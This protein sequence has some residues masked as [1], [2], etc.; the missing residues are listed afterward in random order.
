MDSAELFTRILVPVDFSPASHEAL[1]LAVRMAGRSGA[2]LTLMHVYEP[3]SYQLLPDAIYIAS[4]ELMA[5]QISQ[6]NEQLETLR[7]ETEQRGPRATSAL[8][9]GNAYVELIKEVNSGRH[10]LVVI[11]THGNTGLKHLLLGSVAERIVR[12][13]NCPVLTVRS[14]AHR[15]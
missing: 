8:S 10:D 3:P 13:A 4:P 14:H 2:A 12:T 5:K 9:E 1:D 11:G 6:M 7:R 15:L